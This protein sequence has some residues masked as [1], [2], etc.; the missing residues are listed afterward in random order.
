M[1]N[2]GYVALALSIAFNAALAAVITV[3]ALGAGAVAALGSG[4]A[5]FLGIATLVLT[6]MGLTGLFSRKDA[7]AG[8]P[9]S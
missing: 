9:A 8:P 6:I 3:C 5:T 1:S 4:G 7:G 2:G